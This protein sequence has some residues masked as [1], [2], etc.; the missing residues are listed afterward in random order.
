MILLGQLLPNQLKKILFGNRDLYGIKVKEKDPDWQDWLQIYNDFYTNTQKKGIGN[1]INNSGYKI[2]KDIDFENKN[3]LEIGPGSIKHLKY[4]KNKPKNYILVDVDESFLK[5]SKSIL[6]ENKIQNQSILLKDRDEIK[7]SGIPSNSIDIILT[8]YSLEHLYNLEDNLLNYKQYLKNGGMI[9]GTVPCEGGIGWGLGRM[10]TSRR[11]M[12]KNTNID[13]DKIICWE[14]PKFVSEI[15]KLLDIN[16]QEVKKSFFPLKIN[17][18]DFNLLFSFIY[19][20]V[21]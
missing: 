21:D 19:K 4:F 10:L 3:V 18:G 17:S 6:D 20:K 7:I 8:F 13:P 15:K 2:V 1:F 16:F 14:H 12:K 9:V 11:W 5:E